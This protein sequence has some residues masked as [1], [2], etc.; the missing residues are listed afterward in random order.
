MAT[1]R[2]TVAVSAA[3]AMDYYDK[4]NRV[5]LHHARLARFNGL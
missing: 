3:S 2:A 1:V 5:T 4:S